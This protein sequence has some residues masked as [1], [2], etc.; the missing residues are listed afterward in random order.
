ME[1]LKHI[2]LVSY[3]FPPYYGIGGRR[4]AKHAS[5]L[6]KLGYVVHVICARNAFD[7]KSLW[8]DLVKDNPN[9]RIY[10]LPRRY[11]KVLVKFDHHFLQKILYKFWATLLPFITKG[12][13]LDRTIFWRNTMLRKAKQLIVKYQINH[14]ICSGGPFG[15]MYQVTELRKWFNN[16]FILND[17]R[18]PWTWG[19]NWGFPNLEPKKKAYELMLEGK[20]IENADLFSVPSHDMCM[21]LKKQYP[22]FKDKFIQIPHFFDPEEAIFQPKTTSEKIRLVMYGNIYHNIEAYV[23]RLAELMSRHADVFTLDI[24]T[25]K[26][27]HKQT[28]QHYNAHNVHFHDQLD[29][30]ALFRK[31]TDYDYVFLFSP[32]YNI[33]NISTK[34]YEIISTK[35]PIILFCEKGLGSE[36]IVNNRLGFHADLSGIDRL[37][38][39]LATRRITLD[40]NNDF[41]I[42]H[43]SLP[44]VTQS[45]S[46]ILV[47][48]RPF[49]VHKADELPMKD[50]L[51]TFDYELFL[52]INSG[53]VDNCIIRPTNL[54]IDLLEKQHITKALFFV[55]TTYI[56][57]LVERREE[58]ALRDYRQIYEQLCHLLKKG[59]LILPHIHPHWLDAIYHSS[60]NQWELRSIEKYRF[61]H[62]D[63]QTR[64]ELFA[65]SMSFIQGLQEKTGITYAIDGYRAGGWCLQPFSDFSSLFKKYGIGYDFSVLK[66][67]KNT[68]PEIYYNYTKMPRKA[69][70]R[71]SESIEQED[72]QG[73]FKEFSISYI[74][75]SNRLV[76]RLFSKWLAI[77]G[78]T[79]L[80]DGVS[81][82]KTEE[83]VIKESEDRLD[84]KA[85]GHLEMVSIELLKT[86]KLAAYKK[87][88]HYNTFTH[89]I[90][91]PKMLSSHNL[92]SF[93]RLLTHLQKRYKVQ[94]D[95]KLM[96]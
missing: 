46:D 53:T 38:D 65:F 95:Y 81:V 16:L 64:D 94:T 67:F 76:H 45:I 55:D 20:A 52:G 71:F 83:Q 30:K 91:H 34:F 13:S 58:K 18:D 27:H 63:E 8:W 25:D 2:L 56:M 54:I 69:I 73:P 66:N 80:G 48:A 22:Q 14:V 70:Y 92:N 50:I 40:Y 37:L 24:Y 47:K 78:I 44:A 89:F 57:R 3:V 26:K 79:N 21:Y 77:L 15:A 74:E 72:H 49:S 9:I 28:F 75:I 31:F 11:P 41:D 10:Q 61:H 51:I 96:D 88:I 86:T 42:S 87:L 85:T 19:P 82:K 59:H 5:E 90:S 36:F 1:P 62:I 93:A 68:S 39:D 4:W 60:T 12:S 84:P 29:A 17:L 7:E 35:T 6:T 32:S 23:T 33:N 43:F